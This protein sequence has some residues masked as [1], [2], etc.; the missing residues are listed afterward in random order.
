MSY[1]IM[2]KTKLH[3]D[4]QWLNIISPNLQR[5]RKVK[6]DTYN[7]RCNICGDSKTSTKKARLFFYVRKGQMNVM[8]QN[9]GYSHSFFKYVKD[10]FPS[11]FDEYKRDTMFDTFSNKPKTKIDI[12]NTITTKD[13]P[14]FELLYVSDL[15]KYAVNVSSLSEDHPAKVMLYSRAFTDREIKR[16]WYTDDFKKFSSHI[17]SE[18][19]LNLIENEPRI[20]IPFI[21]SNGKID[22]VQGRAIKDSKWKYISIKAHDDIDK[23]Y[24]MYEIDEAD[25]VYC[26]EGPLDALFVD[27]CIATC[28]ASLTRSDADVLIWDN[29]PLKPQT[30]AHMRN[31]IDAGRSVVI[32]PTSPSEKQDINDLIKLGVSQNLLMQVIRNC[33]YKGLMA[34]AKLA[35]WKRV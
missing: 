34:K 21:N 29:E 27:N 3:V 2:F 7:C 14:T 11:H 33:T 12:V 22:M 17:N 8:C 5:F 24:G 28:D 13:K 25:V 23:I 30:V 4:L 1:F 32:W 18:A 6:T 26:V 19:T 35:Q 15:D 16:L 20:I 9:C 31:A 10:S